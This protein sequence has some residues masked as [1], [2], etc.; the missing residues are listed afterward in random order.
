MDTYYAETSLLGSILLESSLFKEVEI[1]SNYFN[2]SRHK[3]IFEAMEEAYKEKEKIDAVILTSVLGEK[4]GAVGGVM[5]LTDLAESVPSTSTFKHYEQILKESYQLQQAK[6]AAQEF[7]NQPTVT[8]LDRL[9]G[10]LK[11][12][13]SLTASSIKESTYSDLVAISEELID[14]ASEHIGYMTGLGSFDQ[15]TGGLQRGDLMILAARPSVGKTAFA[16]NLA[17]G[18]CKNGGSTLLFSLEMGR[19]QLLKRMIS[20]EAFVN[21]GKWRDIKN[22]FSPEDYE[23]TMNAIGNLTNWQLEIMDTKRSLAEIRAEIRKHLQDPAKRNHLVIIDYLQL[24]TPSILRKDRRDLEIGEI[25]RELKLLAMEL[26]IPIILLSQL[27]RGVETRQDKRPMMS[28]LR[29]S[30]NIEQDADVIAFLYRDDYYDKDSEK[31]N[32]LEVI[33]SKHRNGPIGVVELEFL[34]EYGRVREWDRACG[35]KEREML[36]V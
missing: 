17:A 5:Y 27:S 9:L 21:G 29:E 1:D 34:R 31:E 16:L 14:P 4:I 13:S 36:I 3:V 26:D 30:G 15:L 20:A 12:C 7:L 22:R 23:R 2:Y 32:E 24:I 35:G 18:H 33:I 25:T 10:D 19:R 6:L 11:D 8:N 28:D